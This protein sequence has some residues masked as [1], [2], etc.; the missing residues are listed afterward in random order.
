MSEYFTDKDVK[1]EYENHIFDYAD[2]VRQV[3]KVEYD[4]SS[5]ITST[6]NFEIIKELLFELK[7]P[8]SSNRKINGEYAGCNVLSF[9]SDKN[10]I[11][12]IFE[13]RNNN[14]VKMT[15]E[16]LSSDSTEDKAEYFGQVSNEIFKLK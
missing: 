1:R 15:K 3:K 11:Q 12:L 7:V 6:T 14:L 16:L 2:S 8:Y 9:E 4:S 5:P 10:K 13:N